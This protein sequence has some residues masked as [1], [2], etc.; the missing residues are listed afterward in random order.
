MGDGGFQP[1][2]PYREKRLKKKSARAET[3]A[4][5]EEAHKYAA[6]QNVVRCHQH[7]YQNTSSP[8]VVPDV[9]HHDP[10]SKYNAPVRTTGETDEEYRRRMVEYNESPDNRNRAKRVDGTHYKEIDEKNYT[11]IDLLKDCRDTKI[12]VTVEEDSEGKTNSTTVLFLTT[13]QKD[14][15][16][17]RRQLKVHSETDN[18]PANCRVDKP[19]NDGCFGDCGNMY[20]I[21]EMATGGFYKI[22]H[23]VATGIKE[24]VSECS[25]GTQG[26]L[27]R[28]LPHVHAEVKNADRLAHPEGPPVHILGKNAFTSSMTLSTNLGNTPHADVRDRSLSVD[29]HREK[30]RG[31]A[32]SWYFLLPNTHQKDLEGKKKAVATKLFDGLA[33]VWNG[34]VLQHCPSTPKTGDRD[35]KLYSMFWGV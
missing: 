27:K 5:V 12:E 29:L 10:N 24:G 17:R 22:G 19:D 34:K 20:A 35:N 7:H 6:V 8:V 33:I 15:E 16:L 13:T 9:S 23:T 3:A 31:T 18:Y 32:G 11:V 28:K 30:F 25:R 14:T 26:L 2:R 21:G 4:V 1:Y